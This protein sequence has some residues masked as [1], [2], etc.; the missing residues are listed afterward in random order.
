M[1]PTPQHTTRSLAAVTDRGGISYA[2]FRG[3]TRN[4]TNHTP[5]MASG[6]NTLREG[7]T[8]SCYQRIS[9]TIIPAPLEGCRPA[10]PADALGY[11]PSQGSRE[12]CAVRGTQAATR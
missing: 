3:G 5:S 9:S 7:D 4:G 11:V 1:P 12:R 2:T 10:K 8:M 6:G